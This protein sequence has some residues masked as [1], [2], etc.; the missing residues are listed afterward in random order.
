MC[1]CGGARLTHKGQRAVHRPRRT[2]SACRADAWPHPVIGAR[3]FFTHHDHRENTHVYPNRH[4]APL[5]LRAQK[6]NNLTQPLN[7]QP[8]CDVMDPTA[9][10]AEQAGPLS[11]QEDAFDWST[12]QEDGA[13]VCSLLHGAP[14]PSG[15]PPRMAEPELAEQAGPS[16]DAPR[17][18]LGDIT[19]KLS[20]FYAAAVSFMRCRAALG[21]WKEEKATDRWRR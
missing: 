6:T 18:A 10:S 5:C 21:F 3:P 7:T 17:R 19:Q 15:S 9:P 4:P 13:D 1:G 14:S 11:Q 12:L 20:A 16:A 2:G 8:F